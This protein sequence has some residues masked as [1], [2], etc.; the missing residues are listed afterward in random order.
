MQVER[1]H[2]TNELLEVDVFN[3]ATVVNSRSLLLNLSAKSRNWGPFLGKTKRDYP[4]KGQ[5][6]T[7]KLMNMEASRSSAFSYSLARSFPHM[8]PGT[9]FTLEK[10]LRM[11]YDQEITDLAKM[12]SG[13][14]SVTWPIKAE[15]KTWTATEV[16]KTLL[17]SF[18]SSVFC[19]PISLPHN[20]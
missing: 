20:N 19:G 12:K 13:T 3:C 15:S 1:N 11:G 7:N 17:L 2:S 4:N 5:E 16:A 14:F 10:I 18:R 9:F 6:Q 8:L